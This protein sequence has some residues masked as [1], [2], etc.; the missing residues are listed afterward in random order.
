MHTD[1]DWTIAHH[2]GRLE[3]MVSAGAQENRMQHQ[4][5]HRRLDYQ[6]QWLRFMIKRVDKPKNG[7]GHSRIPYGKASLIALL[8]IIGILSIQFPVATKQASFKL[9]ERLLLNAVSG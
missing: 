9:L 1:T 3:T 4:A 5:L 8:L 6:D 7:N 2:L